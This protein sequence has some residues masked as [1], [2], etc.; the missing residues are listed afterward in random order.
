M[1]ATK[2]NFDLLRLLAATQVAILH[3]TTHLKTPFPE[4]V[5]NI[6]EWFP[7]VPIFFAISG[8]LIAMSY[9]RSSSI[10]KYI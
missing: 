4:Q 1:T 5:V 2:N 9:D 7:G 10:R 8:Y 3:I 6:L